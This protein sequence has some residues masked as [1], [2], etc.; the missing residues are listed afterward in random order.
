MLMFSVI[1]VY[2][3]GEYRSS[4]FTSSCLIPAFPLQVEVPEWLP[5]H[6]VTFVMSKA[7]YW[8][9]GSLLATAY[10]TRRPPKIVRSDTAV[11][12]CC[13]PLPP[14]FMPSHTAYNYCNLLIL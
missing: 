1:L 7:R 3:Y 8:M 13:D 12:I 10:A 4:I 2:S 9:T 5:V 11:K 14:K 6:T